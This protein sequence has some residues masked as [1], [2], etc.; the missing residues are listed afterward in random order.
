MI[1]QNDKEQEPKERELGNGGGGRSSSRSSSAHQEEEEGDEDS[2]SLGLG[3]FTVEDADDDAAQEDGSCKPQ[4]RSSSFHGPET[5]VSMVA[6]VVVAA[7]VNER[8]SRK[9]EGSPFAPL[10]CLSTETPLIE[11]G[12]VIKR[13]RILWGDQATGGTE[14]GGESLGHVEQDA[15]CCG[16]R[17]R[18]GGGG[19]GLGV[20]LQSAVEAVVVEEADAAG[21][22]VL[23]DHNNNRVSAGGTKEEEDTAE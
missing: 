21:L 9:G 22:G 18:R 4:P 5:N 12:K 8:R 3:V 10:A 14:G 20:L 16:S 2:S 19:R 23:Q 17:P 11:R 7:V 6:A 1:A 13:Y 15:K